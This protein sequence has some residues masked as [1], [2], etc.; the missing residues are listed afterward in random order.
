MHARLGPARS[1]LTAAIDAQPDKRD[2]IIS[3]RMATW[4]KNMIATI[5][6]VKELAERR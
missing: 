5:G 2:E 1:G 3:S 6:G 4:H